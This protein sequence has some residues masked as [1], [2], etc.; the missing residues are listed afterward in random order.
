MI[1]SFA[2]RRRSTPGAGGANVWLCWQADA[3]M[4]SIVQIFVLEM[5][6]VGA[7]AGLARFIAN[8]AVL[9]LAAGAHFVLIAAAARAAF[10][11]KSS[12]DAVALVVA[13][14]LSLVL[15]VPAAVALGW[16]SAAP[17]D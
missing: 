10:A 4:A 9:L 5:L 16:P 12:T 2:T 15:V 7:L 8:R 13:P 1:S 3:R 6:P 14:L 11:G 17:T